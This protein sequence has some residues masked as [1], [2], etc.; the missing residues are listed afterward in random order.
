MR[1]LK[2]GLLSL[3]FIFLLFTC[4]SLFIPSHIRV[5]KA[6]NIYAIADSVYMNVSVINNWRRWH[7]SF[8]DIP[9]NE[10]H[11][12]NDTCLQVKDNRMTIVKNTREEVVTEFQKG[13]GKIVMSGIKLITY[14]QS[15]SLTVQWYMDFKL[16]WYPW[17]KLSSL[18][19]ENLYGVQMEQGLTN[20]KELLEINRS[21]LN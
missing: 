7:P 2:L 21:S 15:D 18:F 16:H 19:Y 10:F 1:L 12:L 9:G 3:I 6:K 14:P 8:K 13:N 11:F 4:I 17:E 20:L 5:S